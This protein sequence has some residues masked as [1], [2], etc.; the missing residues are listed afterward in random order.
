MRDTAQYDTIISRANGYLVA[1]TAKNKKS[2]LLET[3]K[4]CAII[5]L[6]TGVDQADVLSDII[7]YRQ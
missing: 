5:E 1:Y 7:A 3:H 4:L 6:L 2:A